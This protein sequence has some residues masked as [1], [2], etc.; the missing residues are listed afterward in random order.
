MCFVVSAALA[1][2][3]SAFG[4][5]TSIWEG[6]VGEWNHVW[7]E[8]PDGRVIDATADQFGEKYP[9]IYVGKP[10]DIHKGEKQQWRMP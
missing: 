1:G 8:A 10:L 7:L 2:F 3:L 6:T 5:E 4:Q 9:A